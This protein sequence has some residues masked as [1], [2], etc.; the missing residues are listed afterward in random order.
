MLYLKIAVL[1]VIQGAAELLPVSSSAHVILT[2]R[3]MDLDPSSPEMTFLLVMLHTGTMF[4]V[5]L[6][7]WPRWRKLVSRDAGGGRWRFPL[8]V[9]I[10]TAVTGIVGLALLFVIENLIM[11]QIMGLPKGEVEELFKSLPLV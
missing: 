5:L 10:A 8:M 9:L 6:Y 3:L 2:E 4:A 1:A 11:V 7:F